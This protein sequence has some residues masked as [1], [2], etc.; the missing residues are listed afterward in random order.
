MI[1][2]VNILVALNQNFDL[3]LFL[4]FLFVIKEIKWT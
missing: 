2:H 3:V 4:I 1:M